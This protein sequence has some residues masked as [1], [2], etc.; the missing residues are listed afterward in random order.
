MKKQYFAG[1]EER[2]YFTVQGF[3]HNGGAAVPLVAENRLG[4]FF[5]KAINY[6]LMSMVFI[7][8]LALGVSIFVA[9]YFTSLFR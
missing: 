7:G 4:T 5:E 1:L 2:N 6:F 8:T 3:S 9:A